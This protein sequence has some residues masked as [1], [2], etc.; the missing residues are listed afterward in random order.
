[1]RGERNEPQHK[2]DETMRTFRYAKFSKRNY[3]AAMDPTP[4]AMQVAMKLKDRFSNGKSEHYLL[5]REWVS[6]ARIIDDAFRP[7]LQELNEA[8]TEVSRLQ[9][10]L[11][12][13][14]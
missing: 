5:V 1:M 4:E 6:F 12:A 7:L 11:D 14:N 2:R 9:G 3:G 8:L 10:I 13:Q